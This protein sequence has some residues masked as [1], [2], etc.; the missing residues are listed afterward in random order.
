MSAET[1][2]KGYMQNAAGH[3]V[4]EANVREHDKLRDETARD[5]AAEA[6]ALNERLSDFKRRALADIADLVAVA[7]QRY[8]VQIGG[9]KGN[10]SITT[11][12]GQYKVSRTYAERLEFTEEIE[13]AKQLIN[14]CIMRWSEGANDNIKVLVDRVFRTDKKGQMRTNAVL[15]L[16]RLDIDDADWLQAMDA[17]KDSMQTSGTAVYVRV[18]KR[19]PDS[20]E[21]VAVPLDLAAVAA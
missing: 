18:Y 20:D 2:P 12:D 15:E 11:Y 7:A 21:Y 4:P 5:L 19:L 14:D 13:A 17:L 10:V 1:I 6:V 8:D 9:A 16:L 3:L